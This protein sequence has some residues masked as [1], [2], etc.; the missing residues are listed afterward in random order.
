MLLDKSD[1]PMNLGTQYDIFEILPDGAPVWKSSADG[2]ETALLQLESFGRSCSNEL[3]VVHLSSSRIV[4]RKPSAL[5][6]AIA[7]PGGNGKQSH[8]DGDKLIH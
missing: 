2:E 4:A 7:A 5:K 1:L 6:A 3:I 8:P